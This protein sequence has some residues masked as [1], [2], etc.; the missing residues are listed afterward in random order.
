MATQVTV[1]TGEG[2]TSYSVSTGSRGPAGA[3]GIQGIQGPTGATGAIG[4]TGATGANGPSNIT[5]STATTIT[6]LLKGNGSTVSQAIAGTD[7]AAA[8]QVK[9]TSFTAENLGEYIAV[10]TLTVTDPSPS[11]GT[12]FV[13]LVRNGTA[14]VGGSAYSTAG[15]LIRRV[16]H[17][18]GW[19]NYSY[20]IASTFETPA[21]AAAQI[22][23]HAAAADAHPV[24]GVEGLSLIAPN[25]TDDFTLVMEGDSI[26]Q[27][28]TSGGATA[29][30]FLQDR[31]LL[32]SYF[33]GRTT[34]QNVA[35]AGNTI[36]TVLTDYATQVYPHRPSANGGK[37]AVLLLNIGTND[38]T[39]SATQITNA[40]SVLAYC[41]TARTDGFEVW[42]CTLLPRGSTLNHWAYFNNALRKGEDFDKLID[43]SSLFIDAAGWS[44]DNLHPNNLGYRIMSGYINSRA[45]IIE[46]RNGLSLGSMGKQNSDAVAITGGT[47][48]GSTG[49]FTGA[50]TRTSTGASNAEFVS[51]AIGA[52]GSRQWLYGHI[53]NA[54]GNLPANSFSMTHY[55]GT[56]FENGLAGFSPNGGIV[57]NQARLV[58]RTVANLSLLATTIGNKA[59]VND[60][61]SPVISN[62]VDGSGAKLCEVA[63]NG[64]NWIVTSILN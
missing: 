22:A 51:Q 46:K 13:V 21:G 16:F 15:T 26:T 48:S 42:L 5:T 54:T 59:L 12:S 39:V 31:L 2:S 14:T 25:L 29:G 28:V 61:L 11:E 9:S 57:S 56:A 36:A 45:L 58:A 43:L 8:S 40:A 33:T 18:G 30:N 35:T 62:T 37:R 49:T 41:A 53:P 24:S 20:Q 6:G 38:S 44:G 27:G 3:Q 34:I 23:T 19:A 1:I 32:E 4:E 50:V 17:S 64:S 60:A 63:Y 52:G 55:N 10:A 47:F 7:F